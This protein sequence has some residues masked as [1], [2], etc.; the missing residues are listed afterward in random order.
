MKLT[1]IANASNLALQQPCSGSCQVFLLMV[2]LVSCSSL[3]YITLRRREG[4]CLEGISF[5]GSCLCFLKGLS[6]IIKS[7]AILLN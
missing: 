4:S 5:R 7:H 2:S 6:L 3:W 1:Y